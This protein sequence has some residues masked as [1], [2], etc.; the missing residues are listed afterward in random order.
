[1]KDKKNINLPTYKKE[2]NKSLEDEF[3]K[4]TLDTF[5]VAYRKSRANA[6]AEVDEHEIIAQVAD[7][8]DYAVKNVE[9]LFAQFKEAAEK[10]GAYVHRVVNAKEANEL[11]AK[12]A[13]DNN[14]KTIAKSKSMTTEET[15][16]N[17]HLEVEGF[18]VD[19]TD[20][21]EWIIQLRNEKPSHMVMP[22]IHL[23]R[24]Q[25]AE[26]F[27]EV[28]GV[29]QENDVTK[30]VGVARK[31][32][33]QVFVDADMGI[34]GGNFAI[35]Q[36]GAIATV[37]NEGNARLVTTLPPV[38]VAL[39]GLDK[40]IPTVKDAM[41]VLQ[42]LPK[43]ATGQ[44]LTAY[45][46][47][48]KGAG[49]SKNNPDNK[50]ILHIIFLDNGRSEIAKDELFS[51]IFRCVRCGACANVCPIYRLIGGHKM[52]HI[53]IGAIGLILTYFFHGKENARFLAQNCINCE[54]CKNICAGNI[55]LPKLIR[56]IRSRLDDEFGSPKEANL[57]GAVMKNRKLFHTLLKYA[58]FAQAPFVNK[59]SREIRH[60]PD[61]FFSKHKF[62]SLPMLAEKSFR[63]IWEEKW[64]K[65]FVEME[66][67]QY[68][69][70][71]FSGCAIDFI[72]PEQL[73]ACLEILYAKNIAVEFPL[74][75]NCCGLPLTML[76]QKNTA[77][78]LALQN[79][80]AFSSESMEKSTIL[81]E[82]DFILTLCSS[83]ASYLK[84]QYKDVLQANY[85]KEDISI[86]SEKIIDFSSF[87]SRYLKLNGEDFNSENQEDKVAYHAS[88]HLCRG[89]GVK[90]EPRALLSYAGEYIKTD[91]EELCCGFG[92]SYS[93]KFPEISAK[94]LE[95]KLQSIE[96]SGAEYYIADCP[97]CVMQLRGGVKKANKPIKVL[98][99][100]EFLNEKLKK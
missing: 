1:M 49:E 80:Y 32:L 72:Y 52:G 10:N 81:H 3:L 8:K 17:H 68:K 61:F 71:L 12:I 30:L 95:K 54:S 21:G 77:K 19:E 73:D 86:F 40:L 36:N 91:E 23:S 51:Q 70:A 85:P 9:L 67:P 39:L 84:H 11:I 82:Y 42:V 47:W 37:T 74:E 41:K 75:Q 83:C 90:D 33:R 6:F 38:H 34:T 88:C 15:L 13:K 79:M 29:K 7:F 89:L 63:E 59:E 94:I 44:L 99:M 57:I 92:G 26:N 78:E 66:N 60:L 43:N 28:T 16:L 35:A 14:V 100:A 97:G 58:K 93:V 2:I 98:H 69:V 48:I 55:D 20:L 27:S 18:Q 31:K 46:N 5:A 64:K 4:Q 96:G 87:V 24:D 62:K 53:Y 45:V 76:A 25:V 65:A 50:K 56:E 22:S